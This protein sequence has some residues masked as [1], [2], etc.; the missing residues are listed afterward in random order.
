MAKQKEEKEQKK[1]KEDFGGLFI[2]AGIFVGMGIGFLT[3]QL[4]AAMFIGM[5]AGFFLFALYEIFR[6]RK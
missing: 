3:D 2:P 5:G 4:V 1:K 6:K